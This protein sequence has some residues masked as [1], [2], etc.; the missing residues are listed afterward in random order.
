MMAPYTLCQTRRANSL[1]L[2]DG[3]RHAIISRQ[4]AHAIFGDNGEY[5]RD[6]EFDVLLSALER[7]KNVRFSEQ[8]LNPGS[9][10]HLAALQLVYDAIDCINMVRR[11]WADIAAVAASSLTDGNGICLGLDSLK[12]V[13]LERR[14][15]K[16][17][18]KTFRD[19]NDRLM[20]S[21]WI[22]RIERVD[23]CDKLYKMLV[24]LDR[25]VRERCWIV[26]QGESGVVD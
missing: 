9:D 4:M 16:W 10:S 15:A 21:W 17:K 8:L 26:L 5:S 3:L 11:Y 6:R 19:V 13:L 2:R 23:S 1:N 24:S 22:K 14:S 25:R 18:P 20:G 12:N 7:D